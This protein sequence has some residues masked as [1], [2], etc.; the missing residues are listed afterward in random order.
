MPEGTLQILGQ[1][2]SA[3]PLD[4]DITGNQLLDLISV[5]AD[6]DGTSAIVDFVP[7]VEIISDAG[8]VMAQAKGPTVLAGGSA[9]VTF[10]PFGAEETAAGGG[11]TEIA[12]SDGSVLVSGGPFGP[13]VDLSTFH[14]QFSQNTGSVVFAGPGAANVP[15]TFFLGDNFLNYATPTTPSPN[16]R[17][18][19][20]ATAFATF[21]PLAAGGASGD[22]TLTASGGYAPSPSS[23][24]GGFGT[25]T[26]GLAL[27]WSLPPLRMKTTGSFVLA[28]DT[29]SA[30]GCTV[31]A[32][33]NVAWIRPD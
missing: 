29:D 23:E 18:W 33:L 16:S 6:Y 26:F 32:Q 12:N 27:A 2:T 7:M 3:V 28:V 24:A 19:Y 9:T 25:D 21:G 31:N 8:V 22:G 14:P 30:T 10:F 4:V 13:V 1:G 15:W 20:Q 11:I 17:G 5:K